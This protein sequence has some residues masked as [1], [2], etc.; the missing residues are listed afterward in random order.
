MPAT[1]T[2]V[3]APAFVRGELISGQ[4]VAFGG[5]NGTAEFRAP[6]PRGLLAALPLR[7]PAG[8][9]DLQQLPF[10]EIVTYLDALGRALDP[11][12]NRHLQEALELSAQFSDLTPPLVRAAFEQLPAW[13]AAEAVRELADATVGIPYL[14]GW[15]ERTMADGR[16]VAV[17]AFGARAVHIIA[18]N[19]P[20][21]AALTI[22]RN[23]VTR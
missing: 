15:V 6:D 17:R 5:R 16:R 4:L 1:V 23:A 8:L 7:D 21:I 12:H 22:I 9:R 10:E 20:L 14:E 19:S 3:I 13:F 2:D 11:A 18:G